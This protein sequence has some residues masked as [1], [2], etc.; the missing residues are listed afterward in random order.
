MTKKQH[1][2]FIVIDLL[3]LPTPLEVSPTVLSLSGMAF[4]DGQAVAARQS[5]WAKLSPPLPPFV[6]RS[7]LVSWLH[8]GRPEGR[9]GV[10]ESRESPPFFTAFYGVE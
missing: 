10:A 3:F 7:V 6:F 8:T 5:S 1:E 9:V 4:P 2:R